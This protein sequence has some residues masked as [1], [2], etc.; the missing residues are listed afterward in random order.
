MIGITELALLGAAAYRGTQLVV[1]DTI[2]QPARDR[3]EAWHVTKPHSKARKFWHDLIN[4]PYC[5]GFWISAITL[6]VYLTA[7][8]TWHD[9][10]WILH[11]VELFAVAGIQ[12]LLNRWD[13]S[14]SP[15]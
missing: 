13:D 1:W 5:A 12:A 8:G 10:P 15:S 2:T 6:A 3:I 4:C 9:A 14:R 7:T 11:G